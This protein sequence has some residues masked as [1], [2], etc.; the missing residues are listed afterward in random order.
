MDFFTHTVA[1]IKGEILEAT[2]ITAFGLI[3]IAGGFLFWKVGS[4]P[5][6]K[7]LLLPLIVTGIIY[8]AIGIS[9]FVSNQKR[10]TDYE[11]NYKQEDS[12]FIKAEKQRV[13]KFQYMYVISKVVATVF[14]AATLLLF[15]FTQST[16]LH[17]LGIGLTLF[18]LSGLVVDYFSQERAETYYKAILEALK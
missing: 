13:E 5:A 10:L 12:A 16:N 7:A 15:W 14:F 17:A 1:W 3:T 6:A 4:V 2:L 9:M 18:A 8:S 11:L